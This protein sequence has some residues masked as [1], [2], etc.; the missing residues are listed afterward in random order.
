MRYKDKVRCKELLEE[1]KECNGFLYKNVEDKRVKSRGHDKV[2]L[3]MILTSN[4]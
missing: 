2:L 1:C 3:N 4:L